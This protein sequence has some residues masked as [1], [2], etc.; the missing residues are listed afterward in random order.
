M[1]SGLLTVQVVDFSL[2]LNCLWDDIS[3]PRMPRKADP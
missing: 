1:R 3:V 2:R